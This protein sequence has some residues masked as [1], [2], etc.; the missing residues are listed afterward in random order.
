MISIQWAEQLAD[1]IIEH[2]G[3][4][5]P[6]FSFY[7]LRADILRSAFDLNAGKDELARITYDI[8]NKLRG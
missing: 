5:D 2:R 4:T 3:E 6:A 8:Q 7:N 1:V